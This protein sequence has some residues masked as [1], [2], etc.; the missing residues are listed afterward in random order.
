[1]VGTIIGLTQFR[2]K[3]LLAYS[4]ISHVGFLLLGLSIYSVESIQAFTFYLIQ[5]TITNL[6]VF[7]ILIM[8]GYSL[9]YYI[10]EQKEFKNLIDKTNSP[11]QLISQLKGYFYINPLLSISFIL[12]IFS[13]VGIPPL[14][15]FFGKQMILTAAMDKGY[16]FITL[17]GITISVI[18][19][20]YYLNLVK[21][22]FFV[23]PIY[24]DNL[25][26]INFIFNNKTIFNKNNNLIMPDTIAI[27]IASITLITT[28]Y[29][30]I[31]KEFLSM[32]TIMVNLLFNT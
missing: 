18:S 27:T 25:A 11:I 2:I 23:K 21:N 10:N 19:A 28:L 29:I 17:V 30:F 26:N 20:A 1:M 15:G 24:S 4:T 7:I 9:N 32:N 14:I 5:Y 13:F 8:M 12:T 3:R 22:I 16:I 6:N 31:N